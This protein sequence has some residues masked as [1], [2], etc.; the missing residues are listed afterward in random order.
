[1]SRSIH[2][3]G[4][5][6]DVRLP[7]WRDPRL[8]VAS[9][10]VS[11]QVLGQVV[12]GFDVS[13]A[14]ILLA[15]G[16]AAVLELTIVAVTEQAIAWPASALLTGNGVALL[17]RTP[18]TVH[19]DWWSTEGWPIFVAA[20]GVALLSKYAIRVAGRP[21][22][23]P[24]NLGLVLVFLLFG[25]RYADPQDL[26][27]GPWRPALAITLA[28]IVVGGITLSFRLHLFSVALTFWATFAASIAVLAVG[29]HAITARWHLGP[30]TGWSYWW[31]FVASP[32]IVIFVFF[33]ITDPKT[34]PIGRRARP[35]YAAAVGVLAGVL[36]AAQR[37]EFATKVSLLAA[38]TIVCAFR[39]LLER[40]L[41]DERAP[42][43][44]RSPVPTV[45]AGAMAVGAVLLALVVVERVTPGPKPV[46]AAAVGDAVA[47]ARPTVSLPPGAVPEPTIDGAFDDY[48]GAIDQADARRAVRDVVEDLVVIDRAAATGDAAALPTVAFGE[49]LRDARGAAATRRADRSPADP[50]A[51]R[52]HRLTDARIVLLRD[53]VSPQA[54][55]QIGVDAIGT[56]VDG[57]GNDPRPFHQVFLVT[58]LGGHY[59]IGRTLPARDPMV[60]GG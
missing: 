43:P 56:T 28:I 46:V 22:F 25:S 21:V 40:W 55:P 6:Y 26:W 42:R 41:P 8:H 18:G 35:A 13:V 10:V 49:A 12:L 45:A 16:T 32:E 47:G 2:I 19:G 37:T 23:N 36:A 50:A 5:R 59:L 7:H 3:A 33:M 58:E 39:P 30:V 54:I 48:A 14:Q 53:P 31:V 9:V 15:V 38:L 51:V 4:R 24:S 17:L 11:V 1:M 29:D 60:V 52:T 57:N 34:A 44:T 27:W 20:A